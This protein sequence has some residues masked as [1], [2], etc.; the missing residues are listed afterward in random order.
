MSHKLDRLVEHFSDV[1]N[2]E[3]PVDND[4][5]LQIPHTPSSPEAEA[6]SVPLIVAEVIRVLHPLWK[7]KVPREH[8]ISVELLQ[9]GGS[10]VVEAMK[11]LTDQIWFPLVSPG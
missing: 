5:L 11:K 3:K 8:D 1:F 4:I 6:L 2:C 7:G 9:L 10:A